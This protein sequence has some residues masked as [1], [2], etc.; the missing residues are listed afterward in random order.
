MFLAALRQ[1]P[2]VL[3]AGTDLSV[4]RSHIDAPMGECDAGAGWTGFVVCQVILHQCRSCLISV[5]AK[6]DRIVLSIKRKPLPRAVR[7]KSGRCVA[8][9]GCA[10]AADFRELHSADLFDN[11]A[12]RRTGADRL[13][14][15][16]ITHKN[17]LGAGGFGLPDEACKLPAAEHAGF[18]DDENVIAGKQAFAVLPTVLPRGERTRRNAR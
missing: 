17:K 14:L 12:E 16:V 9:P 8:L 2:T 7:G 3:K 6:L 1:Q 11:R 4:D 13:Q 5:F 15:F 10:L 18:I